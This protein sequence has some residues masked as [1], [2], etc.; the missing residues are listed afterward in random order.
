MYNKLFQNLISVHINDY[1][2]ISGKYKI[3]EKNGK[4]KEYWIKS[5]KLIF[6]GE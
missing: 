1:K 2:K 3:G 5:N 4:G 6:K